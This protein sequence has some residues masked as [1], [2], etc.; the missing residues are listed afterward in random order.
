MKRYLGDSVY[1]EMR[2]GMLVLTTE[3]GWEISNTILLEPSV[4]SHLLSFI[5]AQF[6][7]DED[8]E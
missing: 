3:N 4:V 1:A 2:D 5:G 8:E 7:P 6:N